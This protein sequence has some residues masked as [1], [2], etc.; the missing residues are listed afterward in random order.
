MDFDNLNQAIRTFD[1]TVDSSGKPT[2]TPF[3]LNVE[4]SGIRGIQ[5]IRAYNLT[6][7]SIYPTSQPF[8]NYIPIS[9]NLV[10]IESITGLPSNNKFQLTIVIY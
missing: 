10:Q 2:Q 1:I 9:N 3:K 4:K 6:N 5:V 7:S 8:I